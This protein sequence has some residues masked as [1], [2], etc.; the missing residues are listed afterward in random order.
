MKTLEE[1]EFERKHLLD[2]YEHILS[3]GILPI[4]ETGVAEVEDRRSNLLTGR[5]ILAVCGRIKAGKSTLVNSL[6]FEKPVL[7]SDDTPHTSKNT[8]IE[9]SEKESLRIIFYNSDEWNS[10]NAE[11]LES[12]TDVAQKFRSELEAAANEGI[13][14]DECIRS[15]ALVRTHNN[16]SPLHQYVTPVEKGGKF[17]PFVKEVTLFYPHPWLR[18]VTV[19]D[20]PGV[21]DPYK[22]RE[23]QTKRFVTQA[24]SILYVSYAGQAMTQQDFD[25]LNEY[26]LH[27]SKD[28]RVIALNKIDIL[29]G[30]T[31]ALKAYLR[32]L[33]THSE[34]SIREV[35]G[36]KM[37]IAFV[38][39]LAKMISQMESSGLPLSDEL[40]WYKNK[41]TKEGML[42][43]DKN[44]IDALKSMVEERLV[45]ITGK[46]RIDSHSSFID[47][48]LERKIR[49]I[50][51]QL[52]QLNVRLKDLDK[53]AEELE[54]HIKELK[55]DEKEL[56]V[57]FKLQKI[58]KD[59]SVEDC[60]SIYSNDMHK[61]RD[62]IM[63]TI[64]A[65][66]QR[67]DNIRSL[68]AEASWSFTRAYDSKTHSMKTLMDKLITQVEQ[69]ITDFSVK[70]KGKWMKWDSGNSL[71]EMID[72]ETF[73]AISELNSKSRM[74]AEVQGLEK[75][76][77]DNTY[78]F[79]RLLNLKE[80]RNNTRS[81][82]ITNIANKLTDFF[83]IHIE[84]ATQQITKQL[85]DISSRM[86]MTLHDTLSSRIK[87][88]EK[89]SKGLIDKNNEKEKIEDEIKKLNE[90][91][92]Q[93]EKLK[94]H[95][96][97][98]KKTEQ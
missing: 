92:S 83:K 58:I 22:F 36:S 72:Y 68:P 25:F 16:L 62:I 75:I 57:N 6:I 66:L 82:I 91:H 95:V 73:S 26:L 69:S 4:E 20:T 32:E 21:D 7:P 77:Q 67:I 15:T 44:G 13:Y 43:P 59:R 81:Q 9:Y 87:Q 78:F 88:I 48:L 98:H 34:P 39:A 84:G 63:N 89:L 27:V 70:M 71:D 61:I 65:D 12:S 24:D 64:T 29:D 54:F 79:E 3:S 74:I 14:K 33:S 49:Y 76:R 23:D 42:Q 52:S 80:G 2:A 51:T 96:H 45:A 90:D 38:C 19:A 11:M 53:T 47:K 30:G 10:L 35:F 94:S 93:V 8:L 40:S 46:D 1:F 17:S 41:F 31:E 97:T 55:N 18:S 5:L 85:S 37:S 60:F 50:N 56:N 28:K 86:E